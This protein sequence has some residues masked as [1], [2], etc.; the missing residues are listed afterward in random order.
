MINGTDEEIKP[1]RILLADDEFSTQKMIERR[2]EANGYEVIVA[3]DGQEALRLARER[4]P[5]V[6]VLDIMMP[7]M[8]GDEVAQNLQKDT[9]TSRIPVIFLTCLLRPG[10]EGNS[11]FTAAKNWILPKSLDSDELLA[12]IRRATGR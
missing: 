11:G 3:N 10:E 8:S 6:I 5:D 2:L 4:H 9:Q 12:M 1:T 7:K